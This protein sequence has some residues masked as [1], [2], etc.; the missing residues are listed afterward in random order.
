VL[1]VTAAASFVFMQSGFLSTSTLFPRVI[2][3]GMSA[4][5]LSSSERPLS[6]L[7]QML[8]RLIA[9]AGGS[10]FHL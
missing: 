10:S 4:I 3:G 9:I 2:L 7:R 8:R 6:G 1:P 5:R